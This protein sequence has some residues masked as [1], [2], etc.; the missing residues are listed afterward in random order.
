MMRDR[1]FVALLLR[2]SPGKEAV[3]AQHHAIAVRTLLHRAPQH[4]GQFES[5]TLP[6]HP[7]EM[8]VEPTI[9][10]FHLFPPV[11]G[12]GQGDAPVRMQMIDVRERQK[13]WRGVSIEAATL[14]L[15]KAHSGYM[16]TISSSNSAPR[17]LCSSPCSFSEYRAASPLSLILPRSPP[18]P[19]IHKTSS[20]FPLSG[21]TCWIFELVFPP[22]KLV[23]RRSEPSRFDR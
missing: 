5:R 6:R 19:L 21:S 23:M 12:G 20:C 3:A 10:F 8:V 17:Y 7:D 16:S 15:P 11:G 13:P 4:H 9:E 18:L 22:P 14:F 1:I 2:I